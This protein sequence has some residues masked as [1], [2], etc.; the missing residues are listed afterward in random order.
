MLRFRGVVLRLRCSEIAESGGKRPFR[1]GKLHGSCAKPASGRHNVTGIFRP[2]VA[3]SEYYAPE[4]YIPG[5]RARPPMRAAT[6]A[7]RSS[8]AT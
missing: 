7:S 8:S 4:C 1:A 6:A 3:E 5:G 2:R